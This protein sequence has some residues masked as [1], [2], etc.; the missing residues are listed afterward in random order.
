MRLIPIAA[1]D[2]CPLCRDLDNENFV[3][4]ESYIN[5]FSRTH[6]YSIVSGSW[7]PNT[8]APLRERESKR[9]AEARE[10]YLTVTQSPTALGRR[11]AKCLKA[12]GLSADYEQNVSSV[13]GR[14]RADILINRSPITP[15]NVIVELKAFSPENT[16][17]STIASQILTTLRRHA[18]FAGFISR[19]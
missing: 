11:L 18:Q 12:L 3:P 14:V 1:A 5:R 9:A 17:P 10:W 4:G 13:H 6:F 2:I 19:Q 15:S 7:S 16:M 8:Y